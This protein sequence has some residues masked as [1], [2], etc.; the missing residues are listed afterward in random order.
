MNREGDL[1]GRAVQRADRERL[2]P[3]LAGAE[4]LNG[5]VGDRIGVAAVGFQGQ[6]AEI[7]HRGYHGGLERRFAL[8]DVGDRDRPAELKGRIAGILGDI[9]SRRRA[10]DCGIV[11]ALDRDGRRR[12][13]CQAGVVGY[14]VGEALA[15]GLAGAQ[16]LERR[17]RRI[18]DAVAVGGDADRP[19]N[20]LRVDGGDAQHPARGVGVIGEHVDRGGAGILADRDRIGIGDRFLHERNLENGVVVVGVA[21]RGVG[22]V[23]PA[24]RGGVLPGDGAGC[25]VGGVAGELGCRLLAAHDRRGI[26]DAACV[27]G[28]LCEQRIGAG[29]P[30]QVGLAGNVNDVAVGIDIGDRPGAVRELDDLD[31]AGEIVGIVAARRRTVRNEEELD[32]AKIGGVHREVDIGDTGGEGASPLRIRICEQNSAEPC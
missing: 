21:R 14:G 10:D 27:L 30:E 32:L 17:T 11:G 7:A 2:D 26:I 31:G 19:Q 28:G 4:I 1:L 25:A 15:R 12:C 3:G 6:R 24:R 29:A 22:A 16:R 23:G 20:S 5:A 8:I 13:R 9:G 18:S